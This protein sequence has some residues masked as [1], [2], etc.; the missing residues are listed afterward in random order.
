MIVARQTVSKNDNELVSQLSWKRMFVP[1]KATPVVAHGEFML[2]VELLILVQF[3][4]LIGIINF[5]L[6]DEV[7]FSVISESVRLR[8]C[9][10]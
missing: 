5:P 9:S 7:M 8:H 3:E 4:S 2:I 6:E 10:T 1:T